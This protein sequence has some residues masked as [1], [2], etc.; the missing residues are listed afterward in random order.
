MVSKVSK[1]RRELESILQTENSVH[2]NEM[3]KLFKVTKETI[4]NDFDFLVKQFGYERYHGG[5]KVSDDKL[6]DSKYRFTE[7]K[8]INEEDKKHICFRAVD[9][10]SDGDCIYIDGGSTV[11]YLLNYIARRKNL[12]IVTPSIAV[13][14]K[15][16]MEG[17]EKSFKENQHELLF[18]GG[19]VH[20][21]IQTTYGPYFDRMVESINFNHMFLSFDGID[22]DKHCTNGDQV[23]FHIADRVSKQADRKI[24]LAD[25]SKFDV[26]K[27]YKSMDLRDVDVLVTNHL[28]DVK[29]QK[30]LKEMG[31]LYYKA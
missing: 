11:S 24:V 26:V 15:Y 9:L 27:R 12:L 7:K 25:S 1:R 19:Q 18:I 28:L 13:L 22:L 3:A 5:I 6:M 30:R 4:R 29:W 10:I 23:A 21:D 16:A 14:T 20:T 2:V 17:L 8:N 31:V